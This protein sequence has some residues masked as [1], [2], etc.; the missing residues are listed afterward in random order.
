MSPPTLAIILLVLL[1]SC[2]TGCGAAARADLHWRTDDGDALQVEHAADVL[3]LF[4][5]HLP[6]DAAR[7]DLEFFTPANNRQIEVCHGD[8]AC[9]ILESDERGYYIG[10]YWPEDD[11]QVEHA[12]SLAHELCHLYYYE[13]G[14]GGDPN[15]THT[16]C[17]ARPGQPIYGEGAGYAWKVAEN[18]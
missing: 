9:T 12:Y 2:S 5:E 17:F 6:V 4:H 15:H 10:T 18:F 1:G 11:Y 3:M 14:E 13:T 16:E 7:T 8:A